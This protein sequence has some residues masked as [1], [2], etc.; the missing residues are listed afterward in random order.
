VTAMLVPFL[1]A[2]FAVQAA[3]GMADAPVLNR[4]VER[5]E[6]LAPGD[7]TTEP[8]PI[9]QARGALNPGDASGREAV[10]GLR[11][12]A[13]VRTSD[14]RAPRLVRRGEPVTIQVRSGGL[15]ISTLGRALGDGSKGDL[16]RVVASTTNRTLDAEVEGSSAVRVAAP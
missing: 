5:G 8:L 7:F 3:S 6:I 15:T 13:V 16:V 2:L 10:R 12:G 1:A 14:V 11:S 9:A 4:T